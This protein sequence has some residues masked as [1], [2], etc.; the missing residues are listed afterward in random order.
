MKSSTPRCYLPQGD[1]GT[2]GR[3]GQRR[4]EWLRRSGFGY[5]PND[6]GLFSGS[7]ERVNF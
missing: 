5:D 4:F 6:V 7:E 3:E 1:F 2:R